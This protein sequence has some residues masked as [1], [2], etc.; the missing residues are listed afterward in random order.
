[1]TW[2]LNGFWPIRNC[3]GWTYNFSRRNV[4][5][6][7]VWSEHHW[8]SIDDDKHQRSSF[9][10]TGSYVE[11]MGQF[12]GD[13]MGYIMSPL[14][15]KLGGAVGDLEVFY[16]H[17]SLL[18]GQNQLVHKRYISLYFHISLYFPIFPDI[19]HGNLPQTHLFHQFQ[20]K[21]GSTW[22]NFRVRWQFPMDRLWQ[23]WVIKS[24]RF[25]WWNQRL[26]MVIRFISRSI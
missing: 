20:S 25:S 7:D 24:Q 9:D 10:S 17:M 16:F 12:I 14:W 2:V 8:N 26:Y 13:I 1:M 19:W 21:G 3:E 15:C 23:P 5:T 6:G 22:S 11:T 18:F 4:R